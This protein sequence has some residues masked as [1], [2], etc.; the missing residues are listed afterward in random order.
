MKIEDEVQQRQFRNEFH[1]AIINLFFT[2]N[3]VTSQIKD[4]L[5]PYKITIQQYNVLRILNGQYPD[6]VSLQDIKIRMLDKMPDISRIL[7]RLKKQEL[8]E[9]KTNLKDK[10]IM[11]VIISLKGRELIEK[12]KSCNQQIDDILQ[13]LDLEDISLLNQILDKARTDRQ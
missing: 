13:N 11:K 4:I 2:N 8:I 12:L 3:W 5:K 1:K 7:E 9:R 6:E 10:R